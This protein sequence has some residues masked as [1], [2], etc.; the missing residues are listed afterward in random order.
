MPNQSLLAGR[1]QVYLIPINLGIFLMG[2]ETQQA[3]LLLRE[4]DTFV[5]QMQVKKPF[6]IVAEQAQLKAF[7]G[8][9]NA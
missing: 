4:G 2:D 7:L 1:N 5:I 3:R 8:R 6:P 9:V